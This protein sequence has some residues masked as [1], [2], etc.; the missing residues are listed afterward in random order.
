MLLKIWTMVTLLLAALLLGTTFAHTLEI[1]A[2]LQ[3]DGP[4]WTRLQQTLYPFFAWVGGPV[5][6]GAIVASAL[7][8]FM[9]RHD[10]V[11]FLLGS[12]A[13]ACFA[14][15]FLGI[16][17]FVTNA[18]NVEILQWS[19]QSVPSDW[20]AWRRQ[21]DYSH[22]ARFVVQLIGFVALTGAVVFS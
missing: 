2:K 16:W 20:A 12:A 11:P 8:A 19:T 5:E 17:I 15:A 4:L 7:L 22:A 6:I 3:Y 1:M 14:L 21:W 9:L 13:T 10:Q 18:A